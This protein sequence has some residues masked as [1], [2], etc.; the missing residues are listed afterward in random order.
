[1]VGMAIGIRLPDQTQAQRFT[2][3]ASKSVAPVVSGCHPRQSPCVLGKIIGRKLAK[4]AAEF[5]ENEDTGFRQGVQMVENWVKDFKGRHDV[6]HSCLIASFERHYPRFYNQLRLIRSGVYCRKPEIDAA[7][8]RAQLA[9][10]RVARIQDS[11]DKA[12]SPSTR[13]RLENKLIKAKWRLRKAQQIVRD[14]MQPIKKPAT[15]RRA[16]KKKAK[17]EKRIEILKKKIDTAS[18]KG[19]VK[20]E[21]LLAKTVKKHEA[22]E[23]KL[24]KLQKYANKKDKAIKKLSKKLEKAA[25]RVERLQKSL[26]EADNP[27]DKKRVM[28]RLKKAERKLDKL[29][30]RFEKLKTRPLI[31]K[32]KSVKNTKKSLKKAEI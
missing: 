15:L 11:L 23:V 16:L 6:D 28:K 24:K 32:P 21:E 29:E 17:Y 7:R 14:T 2:L 5:A 18:I 1:M 10:N 26:K 31:P 12:K 27:K 22:I 30:K 9:E 13:K 25:S 19:K 8:K 3:L 4:A 20:L